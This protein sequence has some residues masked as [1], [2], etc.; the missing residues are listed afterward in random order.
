MT[1]HDLKAARK[2][3]GLSRTDAA[4]LSGTPYSTWEGWEAE[5]TTN[6]R[7]APGIA[8]AWLEL[9]VKTLVR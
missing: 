7:R 3:A 4:S 1:G 8:F 9:Y 5:G 2:K 6:A